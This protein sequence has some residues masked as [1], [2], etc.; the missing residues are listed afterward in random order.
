MITRIDYQK[1]TANGSSLRTGICFVEYTEDGTRTWR[2]LLRGDML[3]GFSEHQA[4]SLRDAQ[5]IAR[6][7][8]NHGRKP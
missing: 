5:R 4:A 6:T 1:L 7:W 3:R 2:V 8:V